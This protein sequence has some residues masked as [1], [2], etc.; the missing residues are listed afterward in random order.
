MRISS[1]SNGFYVSAVAGTYVVMLGFNLSPSA[2][3]DLMGFAIF[4]ESHDEGEAAFMTAMKVFEETNPGLAA[5]A[6]L[7]HRVRSRAR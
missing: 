7:N 6:D 3:H 5:S 4:R 1:Q 2:C